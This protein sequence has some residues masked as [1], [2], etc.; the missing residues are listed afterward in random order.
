MIVYGSTLSPF[1][2]KVVA[3]CREKGLEPE[4]AAVGLGSKDPE[5]RAVSP[6]G[7]I[8]G[9]R[10]GDFAISDSSA[11]TAYLEAKYPT[12]N[13]IPQAP[14]TRARTIWFDEFADTILVGCGAKLFFNRFVAPRVLKRDGDAALADTA[15]A[16]E[17]P[18]LLD[19]LES[20][21]P[22]SGFLVED[23]LT[24]ADLA[25]AS[26]FVNLAVLGIAPDAARHPRLSAY[27]KVVLARPSL[28]RVMDADLALAAALGGPS[29][30]CRA[31]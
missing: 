24:L 26:P 3:F 16:D 28:A 14:E 17:L 31:A 18:P 13:L 12:P 8:P 22:P 23:R 21:I 29:T 1:V 10:D 4:L 30:D 15:E 6:F 7:K 27:L 2:R 11:I 9:F 25:V 20:Q 5:F 19:Y